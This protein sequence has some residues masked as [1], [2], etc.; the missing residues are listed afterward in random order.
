MLGQA[1]AR[2]RL[3]AVAFVAILAVAV[4]AAGVSD[5]GSSAAAL[6]AENDR[7]AA[8]SRTAVLSLYSLDAQLR[9]ADLRLASLRADMSRL[10]AERVQLVHAQRLARRGMASSRQQLAARIRQ[11][12]DQGDVSPLEV[13]L[14]A[15]SLTDALTQLDEIDRVASMNDDVIAQLRS[16]RIHL[17]SVSKALASRSAR[18]EAAVGAAAATEASLASTKAARTS[19]LA[20][21]SARRDLNA[22]EIVRLE[23]EAQAAESRAQTLTGGTTPEAQHDPVRVDLASPRRTRR[24][25]ADGR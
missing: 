8:E 23:A 22:A 17:A 1:H 7:L 10:R 16:A 20:H 5:P 14:G 2:R 12:Y 9:A 15:R 4:P 6:R 24:Q 18:L 25:A 19:F 3:L 11:L 21:L 13:V